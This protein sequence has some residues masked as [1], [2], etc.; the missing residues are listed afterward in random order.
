MARK[1]KA[2]ANCRRIYE[3]EKC[4]AC[5]EVVSS[6]TIKGRVHIFNPEKSEIAE[7]MKIDKEGEFAIKAR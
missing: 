4:P 5:G 3:G 7:N 1:Q 6:D 2:C